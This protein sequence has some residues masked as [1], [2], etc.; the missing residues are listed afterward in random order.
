M[1]RYSDDGSRLLC[2]SQ[3]CDAVYDL[4][5]NKKLDASDKV[6]LNN[7]SAKVYSRFVGKEDEFVVSSTDNTILIWLLPPTGGRG[8]R[9][10]KSPLLELKG[11]QSDV[12][13][14]SFNRSTGMLASGSQD[15]IIWLW[16]PNEGI[17]WIL[18]ILYW[19]CRCVR[20]FFIV[21]Y[22]K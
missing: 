13:S 19:I 6:S 10:V 3:E 11:H 2:S 8:Q 21:F 7:Q 4:L 14:Y 18:V 15:G 16:V 22:F 1:V 9:T 5:P 17:N 20:R 12:S